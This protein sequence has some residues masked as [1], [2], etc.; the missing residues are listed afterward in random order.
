M[1]LTVARFTDLAEAAREWRWRF[2]SA[3]EMADRDS[4]ELAVAPGFMDWLDGVRE[5]FGQPM[6]VSSGYRTPLHQFQLTGRRRG[7][8]VDG[9]A[10]DIL[11]QGEAAHRLLA[12][13][14]AHGVMGV[15]ISQT[16]PM[17]KRYLH[18]DMWTRAPAGT[19]PRVWSY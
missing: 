16:G 15:G 5:A 11:V 18:L 3:A 19:R 1:M 17:A 14:M 9:M 8:H 12:I 10:A 2:F 13:A 7:A 4:G 6:A